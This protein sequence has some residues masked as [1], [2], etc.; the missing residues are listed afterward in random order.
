MAAGGA[1]LLLPAWARL[2]WAHHGWSRFDQNRPLYLEG[3]AVEVRWRNPHA[4]LVL[5]RPE[6]LQLP[7]DLKQRALPAQTAPVDG[8]ALLAAAQLPRRA[9]R[10][11]TI[12][13][14]PL[15]R[16]NAWQVPEI[17][18][19]TE[20]GVLGYTYFEEEGEAVLRAEY[21]FLGGRTYGM[22]SSP[23]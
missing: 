1:V 2:A 16:M 12:E 11:W 3:R 20:V 7:A 10:R 21:L 15:T 19:G 4:E 13:L 14:A 5:E 22:R 18:P 8:P 17:Q 23:A 9:D 6:Q